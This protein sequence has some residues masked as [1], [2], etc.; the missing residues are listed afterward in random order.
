MKKM[1]TCLLAL[2]G[3]SSACGQQNYENTDV[4][5]F[6]A[7]LDSAGV[8][9]VDVR[10]AAE[11]AEGHIA[12]ALLLDQGQR[13]FVEK[14]QAQWPADKTIAVYCRSG[15]RSA[16]AA[17]RLAAVGFKVVNLKGGILA[18]KSAGKPVVR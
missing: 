5:G 10:S 8:V 6:E 13:D 2:L 14:A 15:R 17:S 4:N 3:L 18:W 7:L 16:S 11:Y 9:V 1:I 12:G